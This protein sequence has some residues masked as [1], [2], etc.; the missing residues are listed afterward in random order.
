MDV[1]GGHTSEPRGREHACLGEGVHGVALGAVPKAPL[2]QNELGAVTIYP[3]VSEC[4]HAPES[5]GVPATAARFGNFHCHAGFSAA[6]GSDLQRNKWTDVEDG[7][8][9]REPGSTSCGIAYCGGDVVY[10]L[11]TQEMAEFYINS[12][13]LATFIFSMVHVSQLFSERRFV[14]RP[15]LSHPHE[16]EVL[17]IVRVVDPLTLLLNVAVLL[18]IRHLSL[19]EIARAKMT[20]MAGMIVTYLMCAAI[21]YMQC[22]LLAG[23]IGPQCHGRFCLLAAGTLLTA[24]VIQS[25]LV[26]RR[27]LFVINFMGQGAYRLHWASRLDHP[28]SI[29]LIVALVA[30]YLM[31]VIFMVH[32]Y[33]YVFC[34]RKPSQECEDEESRHSDAKACPAPQGCQPQSALEKIAG[35]NTEQPPALGGAGRARIRTCSPKGEDRDAHRKR[36]WVDRMQSLVS[37]S[38]AEPGPPCVEARTEELRPRVRESDGLHGTCV[39]FSLD[40]L[41]A[42]SASSLHLHQ[43]AA[44]GG[45]ASALPASADVGAAAG[46]G[47]RE[48]T[49]VRRRKWRDEQKQLVSML[50]VLLPDSA[51]R[52]GFKRAGLRSAGVSGRSFFNVLSDTIDYVKTLGPALTHHSPTET[53]GSSLCKTAFGVGLRYRD[54]LCDRCCGVRLLLLRRVSIA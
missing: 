32:V 19:D 26:G 4:S 47:K 3:C 14:N 25:T 17:R 15:D 12:F 5:D 48:K 27:Y 49:R 36:S 10:C 38:T 9:D 28:M 22:H 35:I 23:G 7:R 42:P 43:G 37:V 20:V 18:K 40:E 29:K 11:V 24:F 54:G 39:H 41:A 46:E 45:S 44:T 13:A 30:L 51:R 50:D 33:E 31:S 21:D 1:L 16:A 8:P 2:A 6:T 52:A 34:S 53:S